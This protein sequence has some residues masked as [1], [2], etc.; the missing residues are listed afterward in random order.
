MTPSDG[1]YNSANDLNSFSGEYWCRTDRLMLE[2]VLG[3]HIVIAAFS[4]SAFGQTYPFWNDAPVLLSQRSLLQ[5]R[6]C[7]CHRW[8]HGCLWCC[9]SVHRLSSSQVR[10]C[11]CRRKFRTFNSKISRLQPSVL[12]V[13]IWH[14]LIE[15]FDR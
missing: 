14:D 6:W 12:L 5:D 10:L 8:L 15:P 3:C 11:G 9:G 2:L 1:C 4:I 7:V 13:V